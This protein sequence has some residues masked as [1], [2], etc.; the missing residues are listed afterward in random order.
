MV[1]IN[2]SDCKTP[3]DMV[4]R[5]AQNMNAKNALRDDNVTL[6]A[7]LIN[8]RFK[9][10]FLNDTIK[11]LIRIYHPSAP[12]NRTEK[13]SWASPG[14]RGVEK[15]FSSPAGR[16]DRDRVFESLFTVN[17][18][19]DM[20]G[21]GRTQK[22][23]SESIAPNP[24]S[25]PL[26]SR[27]K[28]SNSGRRSADR[29]RNAVPTRTEPY[30]TFDKMREIS[31]EYDDID[32]F[33]LYYSLKYKTNRFIAQAQYMKDF[34]DD[35]PHR[36]AYIATP[37]NAIYENMDD[38]QLRVYFT[39]RASVRR[40][41][42]Y[43]IYKG[44]VFCYIN[45]LLNGIHCQSPSETIDALIA[46]WNF[47]GIHIEEMGSY[48]KTWLRDYYV[49][50]HE[51]LPMRFQEYR[52]RFPE[53]EDQDER[54]S[55]AE[56]E[57]ITDEKL[58]KAVS[59]EFDDLSVIELS[60]SFKISKGVF[61]KKSN[62]DIIERCLISVMRDLAEYFAKNGSDIRQLFYSVR[63]VTIPGLFI[64]TIYN[65]DSYKDLE[66]F[67]VDIDAN[68]RIRKRKDDWCREYISLSV[69]KPV[70]GFILKLIEYR[71]R[72][73]FGFPGQIKPP[74][75]SSVENCFMS[76]EGI[77]P[78]SFY[79]P[80]YSRSAMS[81]LKPW[82]RKAL[83][84]LCGEEFEELI[85]NSID[86]FMARSHIYAN[87]GSVT[88]REPV[89]LNLDQL[90]RI[91]DELNHTAARL[92]TEAATP[93]AD[94]RAPRAETDI[95]GARSPVS[96]TPRAE[97]GVPGAESLASR[98][99]ADLHTPRADAGVPGAESLTPRAETDMPG[100]RSPVSYTPRSGTG[101]PGAEP[102]AS[103]VD[104]DLRAPQADAD[105]PITP[106]TRADVTPDSSDNIFMDLLYSLSDREEA[107]LRVLM[108]CDG[109]PGEH[110]NGRDAMNKELIVESINEKAL[111]HI[112]DNL[113][114]IIDGYSVF[115]EYEANMRHALDARER[116]RTH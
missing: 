41:A 21:A 101:V 60:S 29:N 50:N 104:A 7:T 79:G 23:Q 58:S 90:D 25:A 33:F 38:D 8:K 37:S 88:E 75:L 27:L 69:Y 76:S 86:S 82:K 4:A 34:I 72:A 46:I 47:H 100:A 15:A 94:L 83:S 59:C 44:Y 99:D 24:L 98:V 18:S 116:V 49:V 91:R 93:G 68:E 40:G 113:I 48:M 28:I 35:Y 114:D 42:D 52:S 57:G 105:V 97:T 11:G 5:Y 62:P 103:R 2:F 71:M 96:H 12:E 61:Y 85:E 53:S 67:Y 51:R 45:E 19:E 77:T 6:L 22:Y 13:A 26:D 36:K 74:S 55:I 1:S 20:T 30:L 111:I 17:D 31:P 3:V 102:L 65:H 32:K 10:K 9:F 39:W 56:R 108:S 64:S 95:P 112:G 81:R 63:Q 107:F 92:N 109:H 43:H 78:N 115:E 87:E 16:A 14:G 73:R 80:K 54:D 84:L 66:P 106:A 89:R 110:A 70:V